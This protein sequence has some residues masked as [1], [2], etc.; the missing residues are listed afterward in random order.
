MGRPSARSGWLQA[1]NAV[2]C[3]RMG[4][5]LFAGPGPQEPVGLST[6]PC[7][8]WDNPAHPGAPGG[9]VGTREPVDSRSCVNQQRAPGREGGPAGPAEPELPLAQHMGAAGSAGDL[10]KENYGY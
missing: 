3:R 5:A 9:L 7:V 10:L 4:R 8:G 2:P 6:G 1:G